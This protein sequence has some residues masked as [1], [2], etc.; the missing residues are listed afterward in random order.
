MRAKRLTALLLSGVMAAGVLAGCGGINA[1]ATAATFE[2]TDVELGLVNFIAKYQQASYDDLYAM[3]FNKGDAIWNTDLYGNGSTAKDD[4]VSGV[5]DTLENIYTLEKHMDEYGVTVSEQ[6]LAD[7]TATAEQFLA[8]NDKKAIKAMG[9]EQEYV[10]EYL[11]LS[12]IAAKMRNA[13]IAEVDTEVSDEEAKTGAFTYVRVEKVSNADDADTVAA[14]M[15]ILKEEVEQFAAEAAES[16]LEDAAESYGYT[17]NTANFTVDDEDFD[18]AVVTALEEAKEGEVSEV[19]DT[20]SY[21]YVVR[22]D[23]ELDREATDATKETIIKERQDT[24][25]DETLEGW[26]EDITWTVNEKTIGKISF[27]NLF[28]TTVEST[29]SETETATEE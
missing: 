15:E 3:Y 7:I 13:I 5:M 29:E 8:D 22:L 20:T 26:K 9:A 4:L 23:E 25:Y 24:L 6:E 27:D 2:K 12:T 10:E 11:R 18:E 19:I 14:D 1:N 21:Y 28:T 16:T 17:I